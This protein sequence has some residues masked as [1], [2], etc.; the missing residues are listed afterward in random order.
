MLCHSV[1]R[2]PP[3]HGTRMRDAL[4]AAGK[5]PEWALY[6]DEGHGWLKVENRVDFA[7]RVERFLAQHLRS[8][9]GAG[10]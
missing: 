2:V 3:E 8:G 10:R 1:R 4:V 9:A 7:G 5:E 6:A